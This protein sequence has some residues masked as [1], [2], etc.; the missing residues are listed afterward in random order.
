MAHLF[1]IAGHGAGDP[2]ATGN[3]YQEA[4]RVRALAAKIGAYGGGDVTIADTSRNW[5]AD[6]G[7]SSLSI[8]KDWQIL[9]LH[10]DSSSAT[11]ARGGHVIIKTG[12]AA[13]AYDKA[14]AAYISSV[15]PG[16]SQT[17]VG[18]NDLANPK[19]AAAKGYGY[20]LME[21]GFISNAQD[22]QIFNSRMDEI[23]KGILQCFG[24]NTAAGKPTESEPE[25]S[26]DKMILESDGSF[27]PSTVRRTQE[28]LGVSVDGVISNQPASNKKYLSAAYTGCW[29]FKSSGYNAGSN[30][31]RALQKLIGAGQDGW[32]GRESV[33]KF[34]AFL[35]VAQDGSMGPDTVKAW[36][37][38]LNEH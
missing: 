8:P 37:R 1:I 19:R 38:Y 4:E 7:I 16:R 27:G 24:I 23:A 12:L 25:N 18:R 34:Q 31:I 11:S 21:C 29:E 14:L 32:F 17:L 30:M 2:G 22:V 6:N 26:G 15:F 28:F 5:Y 9:E 20:R 35:G 33:M 10:M 13:D 36:Q 3:G